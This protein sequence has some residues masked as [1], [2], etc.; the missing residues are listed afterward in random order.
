MTLYCKICGSIT[1][2]MPSL[3]SD[4]PMDTH[5][6][7]GPLSDGEYR[8]A[9]SAIRDRAGIATIDGGKVRRTEDGAWVSAE[10]YVSNIDVSRIIMR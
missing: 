5:A 7:K 3:L 9:A 2:N 1:G 4:L 8:K 10:G 6:C